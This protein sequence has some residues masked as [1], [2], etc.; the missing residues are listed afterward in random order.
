MPSK[1][2][3]R[4]ISCFTLPAVGGVVINPTDPYDV[5]LTWFVDRVRKWAA[6]AKTGDAFVLRA[7]MFTQSELNAMGEYDGD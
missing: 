4:K 3:R 1:K 2:P 6:A 5:E 7:A